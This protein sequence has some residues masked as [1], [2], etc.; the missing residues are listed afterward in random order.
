MMTMYFHSFGNPFKFTRKLTTKEKKDLIDNLKTIQYF[1]KAEIKLNY[2]WI[3]LR[4]EYTYEIIN[5]IEQV[6]N[7]LITYGGPTRRKN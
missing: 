1:D 2:I 5:Q 7:F 6:C 3:Y 4:E